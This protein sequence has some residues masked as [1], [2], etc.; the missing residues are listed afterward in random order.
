MV[1]GGLMRK[2]FRH[3]T[4][5]RVVG[6]DAVVY[7]DGVAHP[8]I[9]WS[10]VGLRIE[11]FPD[12]PQPGER[13]AFR[14]DLPLTHEDLFE[15]DAWAEVIHNDEYGIG[16][17]YLH[18]DSELADRLHAVLRVMGTTDVTVPKGAIAYD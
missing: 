7:I 16:V 8:V 17:R 1:F 3:R 18:L 2:L 4:A 9:D 5:Q 11:T 12:S 14:F 6:S 15:F 13:F 10:E